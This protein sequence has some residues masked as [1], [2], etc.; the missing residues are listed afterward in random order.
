MTI[1]AQTD[2]ADFLPFDFVYAGR[3]ELTGGK[4]LLTHQVV[5]GKR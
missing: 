3:R 5:K 1:T 2:A 4:H